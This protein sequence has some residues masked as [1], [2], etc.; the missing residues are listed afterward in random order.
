M[1]P[2][3]TSHPQVDKQIES[4]EYFLKPKEREHK[5]KKARAEEQ[6]ATSL[7]NQAE[8]RAKAFVAPVESAEA[9]VGERVKSKRTRERA[10]KAE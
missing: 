3:S 4:G 7:V 9:D 5:E 8:K 2:S 10:E 6:T 1:T